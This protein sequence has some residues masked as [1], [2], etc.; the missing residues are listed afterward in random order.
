MN[1]ST[2][3]FA[4]ESPWGFLVLP[5][6]MLIALVLRTMAATNQL[7][8]D[9]LCSVDLASQMSGPIGVFTEFLYD[10]NH[11]LTTLWLYI[12]GPNEAGWLY[13]LPSVI[14]GTATI[15][16]IY[17][18]LK[19]WGIVAQ[20]I[21]A[22]LLA[23]SYI[24]IHYS[25]EARGYA[26][27]MLFFLL[28]FGCLDRFHRESQ[29]RYAVL[30]GVFTSLAFVSHLM[31][32]EAYMACGIWSLTFQLQQ[33]VDQRTRFSRLALCHFL[34]VIVGALLYVV[35][36]RYLHVGGGPRYNG[37]FVAASAWSLLLGAARPGFVRIVCGAISIGLVAAAI[38]TCRSKQ[39]SQS[40]QTHAWRFFVIFL[41]VIPAIRMLVPGSLIFVRYFL[42]QVTFG[43]MLLAILAAFL[44]KYRPKLQGALWVLLAVVLCAQIV[45]LE[46]LL[47]HGRGDYES[48]AETIANESTAD[49]VRIASSNNVL[50]A[51]VLRYYQRQTA[52]RQFEIEFCDIEDRPDWY[53]IHR[54]MDCATQPTVISAAKK[55]HGET[56]CLRT[57]SYA[58]YLSGFEWQCYQRVNASAAT[59]TA[60]GVSR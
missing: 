36:V 9:E 32:I 11:Y 52:L 28:A 33:K 3:Q 16:A 10:N 35:N 51:P 56:Y 54:N 34:P 42:L 1:R 26:P 22:V 37:F 58:S 2:P 27:L 55:I 41:G 44:I 50:D 45:S 19:P 31:A 40:N 25:S 59:S 15:A 47:I 60:T 49:H 43:V 17:W 4:D 7:W 8:F 46:R 21:G 30:F 57:V 12:V 18:V 6:S 48:I 24:H 38:W 53:I 39:Q 14:A 13:R 29:S 23:C 5:A 20:R